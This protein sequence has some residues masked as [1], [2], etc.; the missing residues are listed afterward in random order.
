MPAVSKAQQKLMGAALAAKK[1]E[2]PISGKIGEDGSLIEI[3]AVQKPYSGCDS[4]SLIIPMS[5]LMGLG[6]KPSDNIHAVYPSMEMA[7][8][9]ANQLYEEHCQYEEML[10]EKKGSVVS[11]LQSS[12]KKLEKTRKEAM[13]R[14]MAVPGQASHHKE[15]IANLTSKID[16]LVSKLER[17][18]KSQKNKEEE[19][20]EEE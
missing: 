20:T 5:P 18:N 1:G 9:V 13:A 17:V 10:E 16:D 4:Q 15:K 11:K 12:I 19:K 3:Y 7:E 8:V 14:V 2:K 6:D